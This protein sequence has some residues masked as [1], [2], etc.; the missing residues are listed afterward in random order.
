M[1]NCGGLHLTDFRSLPNS[2]WP[3]LPGIDRVDKCVEKP[4]LLAGR[5]RPVFYLLASVL[6]PRINAQIFAQFL[7][8]SGGIILSRKSTPVVAAKVF[9]ARTLAC[10]CED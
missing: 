4:L 3:Y 6:P 9:E 1:G 5:N 10:G 8:R 2:A 7:S